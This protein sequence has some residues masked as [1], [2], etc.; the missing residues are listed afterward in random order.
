MFRAHHDDRP[1]AAIAADFGL[2]VQR[3]RQIVCEV[4]AKLR[5]AMEAP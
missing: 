2:S 3:V 1:H 4:R 5:A